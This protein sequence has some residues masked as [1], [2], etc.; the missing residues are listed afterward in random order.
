MFF[1]HFS[2]LSQFSFS[3]CLARL[4]MYS[5]YQSELGK[6]LTFSHSP[7]VCHVISPSFEHVAELISETF[8]AGGFVGLLISAVILFMG[9]GTI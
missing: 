7:S 1:A 8:W 4:F 9:I 6:Y 3:Y 5:G 2:P